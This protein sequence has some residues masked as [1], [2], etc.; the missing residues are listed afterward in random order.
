[1]RYTGHVFDFACP[2]SVARR[3]VADAVPD[4]LFTSPSVLAGERTLPVH[5]A[6]APLLPAGAL[7][8]GTAVGVGGGPGATGVALGLVGE[9]SRTGS[10]VA[11]VGMPELG[12]AAADALG[13]D[14]AHLFLVDRV[15]ADRWPTVVGTLLGAVDVV[16][17]VVPTRVRQEVGRRLATVARERGTVVVPVVPG[18]SVA[19]SS[20]RPSEIPGFAAQVRLEVV[21]ST[22]RGLSTDADDGHGHL[23]ARRVVVT[24]TGRGRAARPTRRA[25]WLPDADGEIREAGEEPDRSDVVNHPATA[26]PLS[27]TG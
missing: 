17:A 7:V 8:R 2:S 27:R 18:S 19:P 12:L 22:W 11:V 10:W 26:R 1:M 16:L 25:L 24:A 5:E 20:S 13:V 3:V 21:A 4:A 6:F 15:P 14:L 9:S 23:R